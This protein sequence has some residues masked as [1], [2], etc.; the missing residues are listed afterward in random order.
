M[1]DAVTVGCD[2]LAGAYFQ[3]RRVRV[4]V[5]RLRGELVTPYRDI[6]IGFIL[7][8]GS[9]MDRSKKTV[10]FQS[11]PRKRG[12]SPFAGTA[13]RVLRTKG[14]CPLFLSVRCFDS[15]YSFLGT[16]DTSGRPVPLGLRD[17]PNTCPTARQN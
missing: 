15:R 9:D 4:C 7:A 8:G 17:L 14:D 2:K 16:S 5:N 13:R 6:E 10:T 11:V 12:L 1:H 3:R